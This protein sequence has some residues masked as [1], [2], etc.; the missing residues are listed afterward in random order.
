MAEMS[1]TP[2]ESNPDVMNKFIWNLGVSEKWKIVDVLSLDGDMLGFIPRPTVAL[3]LLFPT[4]DKYDKLKEEQE[5]QLK[6]SGQTISKN[7]YYVKQ[8]IH[9]ACGTIALIHSIGNNLDKIDLTDGSTLKQFLDATK[10]MS[11]EDRGN[12]LIK[13][14]NVADAHNNIALEGQTQVPSEDEKVIHHFVAFIHKDGELYELDGRKAFP[15]NH[16]PTSPETLVEDAA[17]VMS[18]IM[19]KDPDEVRMTVCALTAAD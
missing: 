11:P 12:E 3:I 6:E 2:L 9:N 5:A 13:S 17:K 16:G 7:V 15:I 19:A 1:W 18:E 14:S 10:D 8:Y 4:S